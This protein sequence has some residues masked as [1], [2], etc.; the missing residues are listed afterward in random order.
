MWDGYERYK[1]TG[2]LTLSKGAGA[3]PLKA[4]AFTVSSRVSRFR[5][6]GQTQSGHE[7]RKTVRVM[8]FVDTA[9]PVISRVLIL[10]VMMWLAPVLRVFGT[11]AV[12]AALGISWRLR[13]QAYTLVSLDIDLIASE[14]G[15][16]ARGSLAHRKWVAWV[17]RVIAD[18]LAWLREV[19]GGLEVR[20]RFAAK[21][22]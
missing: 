3:P 4:N 17:M 18:F 14:E 12:L 10:G 22:M 5:S 6:N 20:M 8:N 19:I 16:S 7:G 13:R 21:N 1:P 9:L 2:L 11:A 15:A